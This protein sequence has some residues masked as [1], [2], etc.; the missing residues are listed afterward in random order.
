[1]FKKHHIGQM[2]EVYIRTGLKCTK[3]RHKFLIRAINANIGTNCDPRSVICEDKKLV[4]QADCPNAR[5]A[6]VFADDVRDQ[7]AIARV[8]G[9]RRR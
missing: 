3:G 4:I 8:T 1:M 6:R 2:S 7:I 9:T 5:S